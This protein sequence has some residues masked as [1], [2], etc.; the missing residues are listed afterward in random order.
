MILSVRLA[1]ASLALVLTEFGAPKLLA[2]A[3]SAFVWAS[4]RLLFGRCWTTRLPSLLCCVV[5]ASPLLRRGCLDAQPALVAPAGF[6]Q[7]PRRRHASAACS[8]LRRPQPVAHQG[9]VATCRLPWQD[10]PLA[11]RRLPRPPLAGAAPSAGPVHHLPILS[12]SRL[13]PP[14]PLCCVLAA[15]PSL[16]H[17][18]LAARPASVAPTGFSCPRLA[19]QTLTS[20]S[21]TRASRRF[22]SRRS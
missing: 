1:P 11:A 4:P 21:S 6:L 10:T 13:P 2:L 15:P 12:S 17:G 19:S 22:F 8:R 5:A 18:C 3:P 20:S 14:S 9:I 16:R 7:C